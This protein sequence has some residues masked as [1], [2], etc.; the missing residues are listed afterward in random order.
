MKK[1]IQLCLLCVVTLIGAAAPTED[2]IKA[3]QRKGPTSKIYLAE[4]KGDIEIENNGKI[5]PG[6]QA[7]AF[8]APA[9]IFI[10]KKD[11]HVA[12]VYSNGT[13]LFID[14]NTRVEIRQFTQEPFLPARIPEHDQAIE[15]SISRSEIKLNDGAVGICTSQLVAGSLMNYATP[16]TWIRI[17][18]GRLTIECNAAGTTIDLLEGDITVHSG[19]QNRDLQL[20]R[21][22]ERAFVPA[23]Q[24]S[25]I[26]K[27]SI[28]QI[29]PEGVKIADDRT[30]L[31]CT[32]RKSVTFE[33]IQKQA[34]RGLEEKAGNATSTNDGAAP[35][36]TNDGA[37]SDPNAGQ[38]IVTKPTV[39]N[40]LPMNVV[41][42]PDRLP[43]G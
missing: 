5:Y 15:P 27:I 19:P 12:A 24:N 4:I 6:R 14:Q 25:R 42:S 23:E 43:G 41:I 37:A 1:I 17:R 18:G 30:T 32:A 13:G 35:E 3:D 10:T 9:S 21:P 8:N 2:Q 39:P 28:S 36:A 33:V 38:E 26:A 11:S 29:P 7:Q 34:A 20:L 40:Q 31:A 16:H 22:G